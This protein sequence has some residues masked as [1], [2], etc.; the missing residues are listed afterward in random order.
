MKSP[1][2]SAVAS[3]VVC[4]IALSVTKHVL[5]PAKSDNPINVKISEL[6]ILPLVDAVGPE[7]IAFDSN[8]DGP[9]AGVSDGRIVKWNKRDRRWIDFAITSPNREGCGEGREDHARTEHICGRPLGLRFNERTG[10]LYIADAYMGLLVVGP[11]GGLARRV[12]AH[13]GF[14]NGLDIDQ[15]TG[16]VYFTVSSTRYA[17]RD[18][19]AA[20][21]TG[22]RTGRLMKYD[23]ESKQITV[24]LSNLSFP[25]GVAVSRDGHFVLASE[26]T[27]CRVLRYW[28]R[29]PN[30]GSVEVFAQLPGYPDNI[31]RNSRGEF[32]VGIYTKRGKLLQWL[33]SNPRVG[34]AIVNL[35]FN[36]MKLASAFV[37][38]RA[39][40]MAAK[41]SE[42]GD[43]LEVV[44]ERS[45]E[46]RFISEVEE[47]DGDLWFGSVVL[48]FVG[49]YRKYKINGCSGGEVKFL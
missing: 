39:V 44:E 5:S 38:L 19:L 42:D 16:E 48:P 24:L 41:L 14:A 47:M 36:V 23:P 22:E 31:K 2:L 35:P 10:D 49:V 27:S 45:G 37:R 9:Y 30:A 3:V 40:G 15:R 8:G 1:G 33:L 34:E 46:L 11:I 18:Y 6:E 7:S 26:S 13:Y 20:I 25:N 43:T 32:W 29:T 21:I 4:V 28:L 12:E 17:R